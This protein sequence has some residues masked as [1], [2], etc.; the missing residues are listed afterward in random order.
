MAGGLRSQLST[1][2]LTCRARCPTQQCQAWELSKEAKP[3]GPAAGDPEPWGP[4]LLAGDIWEASP[5]KCHR[6]PAFILMVSQR[7]GRGPVERCRAAGS[8]GHPGLSTVMVEGDSTSGSSPHM[9][10][11]D[12]TMAKCLR[13]S[14]SL[15]AL[16]WGLQGRME[17]GMWSF[18][19]AVL[20]A[21]GL[22]RHQ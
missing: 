14:P 1:M 8:W 9:E 11:V 2:V 18:L 16:V 17:G 12:H 4:A 21:K 10:G 7:G 19:H 3:W 5:A 20:Q 15:A 6:C 22:W 13:G